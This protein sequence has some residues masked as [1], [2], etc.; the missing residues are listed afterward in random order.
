MVINWLLHFEL[1]TSFE[2]RD[3]RAWR[4]RFKNWIHSCYCY[5]NKT[6]GLLLNVRLI[7][8]RFLL[9]C[10]T[11]LSR[12]IS[13]LY[14]DDLLRNCRISPNISKWSG[15]KISIYVYECPWWMS[16]FSHRVQQLVKR[17][18]LFDWQC[19]NAKYLKIIRVPKKQIYRKIIQTKIFAELTKAPV[20]LISL[21]ILVSSHRLTR[22]SRS[23]MTGMMNNKGH[24]E[25]H[26]FMYNSWKI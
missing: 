13:T 25:F 14:K 15:I 20:S 24:D 19:S 7:F 9:G 16:N 3:Q 1:W 5:G 18:Y 12:F 22:K 8:C 10:C 17:N 4:E 11:I 26:K 2:S 6:L 21:L 23:V